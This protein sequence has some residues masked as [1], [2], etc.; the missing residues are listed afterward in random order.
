[1]SQQGLYHKRDCITRGTVSQEGLYHKRNCVTTGTVSQ[2]G[3]YH[4]DYSKDHLIPT[5]GEEGGT[6]RIA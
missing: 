3:L 2:E 6:F 4:N 1:M 5:I